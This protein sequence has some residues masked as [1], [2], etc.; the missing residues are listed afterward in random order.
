[1]IGEPKKQNHPVI[2][3]LIGLVVVMITG[4]VLL[5]T[6]YHLTFSHHGPELLKPLIGL[7]SKKEESLIM[8]EAKRVEE[9]ELHRRFHHVV[10]SPQWPESER[11]VCFICHSEYPHSK[12]RKIRSILNMHTQYFACESCHVKE[13]PGTHLFFKWYSPVEEN[14]QGPF[15]GT[16][17]DPE[18]GN[19]LKVEDKLAKI[20]PFFMEGVKLEIAI[21]RQDAPLAKDF[22]KVR[23]KLTPEQREGVKNKFHVNIKPKGFECKACHAKDSILEYKRLGFSEDRIVDLQRLNIT[24][25]L[26]KYEEFYLPDL[27]KESNQ[28]TIKK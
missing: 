1:L 28:N 18:T 25:M 5:G 14:P 24:G 9:M 26:T 13:K 21:Q 17:Y 22:M 4:L 23:D 16:R 6:L 3:Y 2:A 15:F 20:T 7:F 27:F 11:P 19:L 8:D 10:S 12:N